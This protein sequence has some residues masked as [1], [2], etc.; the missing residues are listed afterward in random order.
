[1]YLTLGCSNLRYILYNGPIS[2]NFRH[3]TMSTDSNQTWSCFTCSFQ[4][5][6]SLAF[7]LHVHEKV[8]MFSGSFPICYFQHPQYRG[9]SSGDLVSNDDRIFC[10][11]CSG[12]FV[13]EREHETRHYSTK[14]GT[15]SLIECLRCYKTFKSKSKICN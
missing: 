6:D 3:S 10:Q 1:M 11:M 8:S 5:D 15:G 12:C 2:N 13:G 14:I 7:C 4:F 9:N